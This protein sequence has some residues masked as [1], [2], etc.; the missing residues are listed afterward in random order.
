MALAP[1]WRAD[2]E[3]SRPTLVARRISVGRQDHPSPR[4]T[5]AWRYD[6]VRAL[7]A[8][9]RRARRQSR[10]RSAAR[11]KIA[12]VE[13]RWRQGGGG[14]R[15]SAAAIRRALPARL[16]A[17]GAQNRITGG[18]GANSLSVGRANAS[19]KMVG[20]DRKTAAPA[21]RARLG[22][23]FGARQRPQSL[24]RAVNIGA[25]V[26]KA[27]ELHQHPARCAQ[28]RCDAT[29]RNNAA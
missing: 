10:A 29:R 22:W 20:A 7:R 25:V 16:A 9:N 15:R 26:G 18:A 4:R 13:A 11:T 17:A 5:G 1:Y 3:E 2:A 28:C 8:A 14:A 21:H 19:A 24:D 27:G 23:Q 12:V 6:S